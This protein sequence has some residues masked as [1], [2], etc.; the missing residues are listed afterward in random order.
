MYGILTC[1]I[2]IPTKPS[3][4]RKFE[5][6]KGYNSVILSNAIFDIVSFLIFN[7]LKA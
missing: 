3:F 5:I 6:K 4:L 2:V 1:L 7:I